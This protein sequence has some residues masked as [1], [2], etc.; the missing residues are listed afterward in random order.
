MFGIWSTVSKKWCFGIVAPTKDEAVRKLEGKIGWDAAKV[1]FE[2]RQL[3]KADTR[4]IQ[5]ESE[6]H[7]RARGGAGKDGRDE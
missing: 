6:R 5:S 3:S 4:A 1:R 2:A 7:K